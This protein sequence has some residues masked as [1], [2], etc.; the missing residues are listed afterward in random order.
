ME[1]KIISPEEDK[2]QRARRERARRFKQ[3]LGQARTPDKRRSNRRQAGISHTARSNAT[4]MPT[5]KY[6]R[7]ARPER[8]TRPTGEGFQLHTRIPEETE[9]Y[10]PSSDEDEERQGDEPEWINTVHPSP[11]TPPLTRPPP[12]KVHAAKKREDLYDMLEDY[13]TQAKMYNLERFGRFG[14]HLLPYNGYSFNP[15]M[16]LRLQLKKG[17]GKLYESSVAGKTAYEAFAILAATAGRLNS[18]AVAAVEKQMREVKLAN[19]GNDPDQFFA[20]MDPLKLQ[21][22]RSGGRMDDQVWQRMIVEFKLF[23]QNTVSMFSTRRWTRS[24]RS[25]RLLRIRATSCLLRTTERSWR[26][27]AARTRRLATGQLPPR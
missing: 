12:F 1:N 24:R 25:S 15:E 23:P 19:E 5:R 8:S 14:G 17:A 2:Q 3:M 4:P 13:Q 9:D 27:G 20:V 18:A 10:S 6:T 26:R 7:T 11:N 21:H 16:F 22:K